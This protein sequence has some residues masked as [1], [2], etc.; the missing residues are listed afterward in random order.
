ML[1]LRPYIADGQHQKTGV[2]S[3]IVVLVGAIVSNMGYPILDPIVSLII[4]LL[5]FRLAV[6]L[7][8]I[9]FK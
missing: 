3:S 7:F 1:Y 5:I 8:I 9:L 6:K 4:G 2:F